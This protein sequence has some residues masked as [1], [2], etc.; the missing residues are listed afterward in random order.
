MVVIAKTRF[1]SFL[2]LIY[3][4]P[5]SEC[6]YENKGHFLFNFTIES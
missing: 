1:G 6:K 5:L 2:A 4:M 3:K